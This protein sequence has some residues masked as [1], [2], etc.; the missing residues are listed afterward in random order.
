MAGAVDNQ[1]AFEIGQD[2][3]QFMDALGSDQPGNDRSFDP[4]MN[5][6]G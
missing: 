2:P 5:R 6:D 1:L 3:I 4:A